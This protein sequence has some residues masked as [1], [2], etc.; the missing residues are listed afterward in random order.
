[1]P[2]AFRGLTP[3]AARFG[4]ADDVCRRIILADMAPGEWHALVRAIEPHAAEIHAW[5]D[6]FDPE[7]MSPEAAAF[8]Y[9]LL[10]IAEHV[11]AEGED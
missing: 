7:P 1:M 10:G 5:L 2:A 11:Q 9:L 6:S 4:I 8:M 3:W